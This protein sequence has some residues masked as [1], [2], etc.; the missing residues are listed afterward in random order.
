MISGYCK[1]K[2]V[3]LNHF[4]YT[5]VSNPFSLDWTISLAKYSPMTFTNVL[6]S[7]IKFL[8]CVESKAGSGTP[9]CLTMQTIKRKLR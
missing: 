3:V 7:Q 2:W 9:L 8:I 4:G 6:E 5:S 1:K